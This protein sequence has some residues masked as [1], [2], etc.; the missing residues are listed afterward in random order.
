M[1]D[2]TLNEVVAND[3]AIPMQEVDMVFDLY[4]DNTVYLV[5]TYMYNTSTTVYLGLLFLQPFSGELSLE[6]FKS[7]PSN[8]DSRLKN[9]GGSINLIGKQNGMTAPRNL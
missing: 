4:Q 6:K 7:S 8:K 3:Q 1:Q 2:C 5:H 9:S